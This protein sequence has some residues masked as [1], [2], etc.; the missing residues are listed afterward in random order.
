MSLY[1]SIFN[2]AFCETANKSETKQMKER[3]EVTELKISEIHFKI[4]FSYDQ[5]THLAPKAQ[6]SLK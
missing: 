5:F 4:K 3:K 6:T 1:N 2:V